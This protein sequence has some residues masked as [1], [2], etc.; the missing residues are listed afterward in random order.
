MS[1][2]SPS[3]KCQKC[4]KPR[5]RQGKFCVVCGTRF[6]EPDVT[7]K[8]GEAEETE[9]LTVSIVTDD[10]DQMETAPSQRTSPIRFDQGINLVKSLRENLAIVLIGVG[11]ISIIGAIAFTLLMLLPKEIISDLEVP[12]IE[13][14]IFDLFVIFGLFAILIKEGVVL[15]GYLPKKGVLDRWFSF[16]FLLVYWVNLITFSL[17]LVEKSIFIDLG[18]NFSLIF[19]ILSA[20]SIIPSFL[21]FRRFKENTFSGIL[22]INVVSVLYLF[23][24]IAPVDPI[25]YTVAVYFSVIIVVLI[26]LKW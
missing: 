19:I 2:N 15:L 14:M 26:V 7:S 11:A 1:N 3:Q 6:T 10:S 13:G 18:I 25:L 24:W 21:Y 20:H 12:P 17:G 5:I 16:V 22:S 4:G 8:I 23:Q 9:E